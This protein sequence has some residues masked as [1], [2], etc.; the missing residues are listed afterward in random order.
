MKFL[1]DFLT[2]YQVLF[3]VIKYKVSDIPYE[4]A[5]APR[6]SLNLTSSPQEIQHIKIQVK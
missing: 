1:K 2:K 4:V 3:D 6:Y 5:L